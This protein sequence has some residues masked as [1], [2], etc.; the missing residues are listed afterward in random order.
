MA[1]GDPSLLPNNI[2]QN[3]APHP[4]SGQEA[5]TKLQTKT[6]EIMAQFL[7][8]LPSNYISQVNGP[9]YTLQFQAL[10][11][12]IAKIQCAAQEVSKD[13]DY[14]FTRVEFLWQIIGALVFPN[15]PGKDGSIPVVEGDVDYRTFLKR[16]V[17]L[18]L[19]GSTATTV[20]EGAGLLTTGTI[21]VIE[22]F[23]GARDPNSAWTIDD[24][25]ALEV[26][27]ENGGG[28]A[29][30]SEDP[31]VLQENILLILRALK[32]A[33]TLYEYR[34]LF[35]DAF[36]GVL[37]PDGNTGIADDGGIH[38]NTDRPVGSTLPGISWDLFTYYY[39][40]MRRF[41]F[42]AKQITSTAGETLTDQTVFRDTTRSFA[43]GREGSLL[44]IPAGTN[45]GRYTV[46]SVSTFVSSTDTVSRAYTTSPTG[47]TGSATV[48]N[49]VILD[50]AQDF[51]AAVE[52]EV[53][54][55]TAGPNAGS[56]RLDTLIGANGGA[57]G[58]STGPA[59]GVRPSPGLLRVD[60]RMPA[61]LSAQ[62]YEVT[63][64]RLG[65]RTPQ[66]VVLEDAT[67]QFYI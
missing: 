25:F 44:I 8:V 7:A 54:T 27:V 4:I 57:V 12:E 39:D 13:S 43:N 36:G 14:D 26:N 35:R 41:C 60:R 61:A 30:P 58:V 20:Q 46:Q 21:T 64:D 48:V 2:E 33:H 47:L 19:Q 6:N 45:V 5:L 15:L 24:Q 65:V 28:T 9:F 18:L 56:Y 53:L 62:S 10:A 50:T 63:V 22:R 1:N 51:G 34:H 17:L 3:P 23:L 37:L 16:M 55:F 52:G 49:G 29:F 59:T 67:A 66:D 40:D 11:Y 42:G 38:G 32:P 31:F